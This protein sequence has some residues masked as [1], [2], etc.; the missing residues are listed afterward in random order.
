MVNQKS[1]KSNIWKFYLITALGIRFI[2]PIR[3][4]YLLSFGLS[5]AQIGLMELAAAIVI[6]VLEIPSGI[7][8]DIVG[9]KASRLIAYFFSIMAFSLMSLGS[10][11]PI[12]ILGWSLSGA[13]DAFQSGAQDALIFDTLKQLN[14]ERGYLKIKSHFIL[15]NSISVIIG[16]VIGAYLY[17]YDHRLPWYLITATIILSTLVFLTVKEPEFIAKSKSISVQLNQFKQSLKSSLS[18]FE[19]KKLFLLSLF[20]GLPMY[21]FTTLLNQPYLLNQGFTVQSMGFIFA[22]ITGISGLVASF[23]HKIEPILKQR[24]SFFLVIV[25]LASLLVSMGLINHPAIVILIIGFYVIDSFKNVIIDNYLNLSISSESR[26]TVISAQSFFNNIF[27]SI[28]FV[29]VGYLVDVFSINHV[30]ISLGIFVALSCLP[31]WIVSNTIKA[32]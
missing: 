25:F 2:T 5:F 24:L 29:F 10:T 20:L 22:V 1:L 23:S 19:V 16:S 31:L 32:K 12:F 30:L 11:L 8:A 14:K 15:I 13:A 6:I 27:I 4:L 9:R 7:F 28:V 21:V 18:I 26:A 17:T 3:I